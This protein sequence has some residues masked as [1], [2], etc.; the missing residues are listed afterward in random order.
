[1]IIVQISIFLKWKPLKYFKKTI[2]CKIIHAFQKNAR[3]RENRDPAY[4]RSETELF[5][6]FLC[7]NFNSML[8]YVKL[9]EI[10]EMVAVKLLN[11]IVPHLVKFSIC[12]SEDHLP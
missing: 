5:N 9:V 8:L 1:M 6:S 7:V 4:V 3:S 11:H 2:I 10:L 12:L